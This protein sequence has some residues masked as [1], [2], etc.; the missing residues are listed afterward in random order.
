[1]LYKSHSNHST[2]F[3][4]TNPSKPDS[5]END[6]HEFH[7]RLRRGKVWRAEPGTEEGAVDSRDVQLDPDG[8][9]DTPKMPAI[10]SSPTA[11]CRGAL[12]AFLEGG[13]SEA[14]V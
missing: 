14:S 3:T 1:M 4:L 10:T 12:Q 7:L 9:E 5:A 8:A 13:S 2:N 6:N 11:G